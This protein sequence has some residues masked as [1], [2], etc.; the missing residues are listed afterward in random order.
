MTGFEQPDYV[1][2]TREYLKLNYSMVFKSKELFSTENIKAYNTLKSFEKRIPYLNTEMQN[3]VE[4]VA[5]FLPLTGRQSNVVSLESLAKHTLASLEN[6]NINPLIKENFRKELTQFTTCCYT[7]DDIYPVMDKYLKQIAS[8][9]TDETHV[10]PSHK[11]DYIIARTFYYSIIS[12][13]FLIIAGYIL[14]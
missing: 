1:K 9:I 4:G 7:E 5:H 13:P 12:A 8:S 10:K 3:S 11:S 6:I 14:F 2:K